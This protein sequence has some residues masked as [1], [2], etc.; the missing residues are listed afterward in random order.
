MNGANVELR[1]E[2][3]IYLEEAG[4]ADGKTIDEALRAIVEFEQF[5]DERDFGRITTDNIRSFKRNLEQRPSRADGLPL[6]ASSIVHKLGHL[7]KFF[8]WLKARPGFKSLNPDV[9]DFLRAPR[10]AEMAARSPSR[11]LGPDLDQVIAVLNTMETATLMQRRDRAAIALILLTGIRD[12]ALVSLRRK[13]IDLERKRIYQDGEVDTKFGKRMVT[14]FFPVPEPTASIVSSWVEEL[15]G[16]GIAPDDPLLPRNMQPWVP[17]V[18][19]PGE[20]VRWATAGPIRAILKR[21]CASAGVDYFVP[22]AIRKTLAV[23]GFTMCRNLREL[24]AWSQNLGHESMLTTMVHYAALDDDTK[25]AVL[26]GIAQRGLI[27]DVLKMLEAADEQ[28][29][30]VVRHALEL[31]RRPVSAAAGHRPR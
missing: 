4:G 15:D 3:S 9:I 2:Y 1:Y 17:S 10:K 29:L 16:L 19:R 28:T 8:I 13:H 25:G 5:V 11:R 22:H 20:L 27:E 23:L 21:A 18:R 7:R 6:S 14:A 12:A 30:V 24:K 26:D 31:G